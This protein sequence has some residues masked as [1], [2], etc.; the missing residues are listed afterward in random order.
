[1]AGGE[2]HAHVGVAGIH[3]D[4]PRLANGLGTDDGMVGL[5]ITAFEVDG[6]VAGPQPLHERDE[7]VGHLVGLVVLVALLAEHARF[8][9]DCRRP[10]RRSGPSALGD[11][12]DG[13]AHLGDVDR[14]KLVGDVGRGEDGHAVVTGAKQAAAARKSSESSL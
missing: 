14:M 3:Q 9:A 4:R 13:G 11:E 8:P 6:L 7:L 12:V 1:M 2:G 10:S 5:E